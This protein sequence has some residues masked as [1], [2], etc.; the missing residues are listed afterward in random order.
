[1]LHILEGAC[2]LWPK[3]RGVHGHVFLTNIPK[4][5]TQPKELP[6]ALFFPQ[7]ANWANSGQESWE[8]KSEGF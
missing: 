6:A 8:E 4:K 1:M 5:V 2:F 7:A 3:E